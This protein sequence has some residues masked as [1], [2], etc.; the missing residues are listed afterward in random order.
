[1]LNRYPTEP[2]LNYKQW[3]KQH[4]VFNIVLELIVAVITVLALRYVFSFINHTSLAAVQ[5]ALAQVSW[6]RI[7]CAMALT[8]AAY[9][10]MT[11]YDSFG[12][13]H[14][15]SRL[16][17]KKI[18]PIA[19]MGDV[20]NANLGLSVLVGSAI[21]LH[22]YRKS[23][24]TAGTVLKAIAS[25][26]IA[27]WAGM[28]LLFACVRLWTWCSGSASGHSPILDTLT[29]FAI[30]VSC[31]YVLLCSGR[32]RI[33]DRLNVSAVIPRGGY[34][35]GL[36]LI[37][38]FD[39][40]LTSAAFFVLFPAATFKEFPSFASGYLLSQ[41]AGIIGQTP[42]GIG[43]FES[44][45]MSL[46]SSVEPATLL[47]VLFLFRLLF[48]IIPFCVALALFMLWTLRILN[49]L[50]NKTP[51]PIIQE[52]RN[53]TLPSISVVVPAYNEEY[54]L[55]ECLKTL[56]DQDYKGTYEIIVVDNA[57]TDATAQIARSFGCKV[58][59]E[60]V[61]GY[62]YAIRKGFAEADGEIIAC[63]DADT[64][65]PKDWLSKIAAN[66]LQ[67]GVVACGGVFRFYDGSPLMRF[68]GLFGRFNYHI[69]G[70]N[71]GVWKDAYRRTG[72]FKEEVNLGADVEIGFRLK[73][74]GSV[75]IDRRLIASTSSR[76]FSLA[77]WKTIFTY[78]FNDLWLYLFKKPF[79][80]SFRD[81]RITWSKVS[82]AHGVVSFAAASIMLLFAGWMLELPNNQLFG[83]VLAK[84]P[85]HSKIVALT[86]DDGPGA[87]TPL[88]LDI[89]K[90]Y[91]VKATFF[92]IG[93]N[94]KKNPAMVE[95][96]V[97][98]GHQIGN[99]TFNHHL[100]AAV[101]PPSWLKR[102]LDSTSSVIR[103][104]TGTAPSVFRP[105]HGWRNPWM[106][107]ECIKQGLVLVMWSID[108]HDWQMKSSEYIQHRVLH[109][110]GEGSIILMH[111]RVNTGNDKGMPATVEALP[112]ILDSLS[113]AGFTF[114]TVSELAA[115]S[116]K[117]A[118]NKMVSYQEGSSQGSFSL[119]R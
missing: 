79:F 6:T 85:P 86:F 97:A 99:H 18:A 68:F 81:Y 33:A 12:L 100:D 7:F 4:R 84:G 2:I 38:L 40:V 41:A 72:G 94:A 46:H 76:R 69:A 75:I 5:S 45:S 74:L 27:Y 71:M 35:V 14:A 93:K 115:K 90:K 1:M 105:P 80:H 36:L 67:P 110:A 11:G 64:M 106:I 30:M 104:I 13:R 83:T 24:E 102:E 103:T 51:A 48:Y 70:A 9:L 77:F 101:E 109:G 61:K 88:I 59:H 23:G 42:G 57:S 96:I 17:Y 28:S 31:A 91:K 21:K 16:P 112:Q 43:I 119:K 37:S 82:P 63:T 56:K 50:P 118:F 53:T 19:F 107:K 54:M 98:E 29:V 22:L 47:A 111:D 114:V 117:F 95:R 92:V 58:L 65:L 89:L 62:N 3:F 20:F 44:V 49:F 108:S 66:L 15:G 26:T 39:W 87:S 116:P 73:K 34:G 60:S 8:I 32:I 25:Y 55:P 113:R 10:V 52:N 78:Y